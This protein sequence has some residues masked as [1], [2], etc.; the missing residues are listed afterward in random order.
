MAAG[1]RSSHRLTPKNNDPTLV[2]APS[3]SQANNSQLSK[4]KSNMGDYEPPA[5]KNKDDCSSKDFRKIIV[6][7]NKKA[8][9]SSAKSTS[10]DDSTDESGEESAFEEEPGED[11][12]AACLFDDEAPVFI[13]EASDKILVPAKTHHRQRSCSSVYS[14][15]DLVSLPPETDA[16]F[17]DLDSRPASEDEEDVVDVQPLPAPQNTR[18]RSTKQ[19]KLRNELPRVINNPAVAP[20]T[21]VHVTASSQSSPTPSAAPGVP[22]WLPHTDIA[23]ITKGRS[24]TL[25]PLSSQTKIMHDVINR[26]IKIVNEEIK[27][28]GSASLAAAA[29]ELN[30]TQ[31]NGVSQRLQDGDHNAYIKPLV[32]YSSH[33]I[34]LERK[35]LKLSQIATVL[36]AFGFGNDPASRLKAQTL[37]LNYTYHYGNLPSGEYDPAKPFEHAALSSYIGA[38]FFGTHAYAGLLGKNKNIHAILSDYSRQCNENFPSKELAGVWKSALAILSNIE[39]VNKTRY[40]QLMHKLYINASGSLSPAGT[41]M[42][43]QQIMDVVDWSAFADTSTSVTSSS[44]QSGTATSTVVALA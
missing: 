9:K 11:N 25:G 38:M 40:H 36:S 7:P 30:L 21:N 17:T 10:S 18:K 1:R 4:R 44:D 20:T 3:N 2:I 37:V 39:K 14:N 6:R 12:E 24:V 23:V 19:E 15:D 8:S 41:L 29:E 33:R 5:K 34:G 28:L 13:E 35:D 31:D 32:N 27:Q 22:Q 43:N 26:S 42:T 16:G